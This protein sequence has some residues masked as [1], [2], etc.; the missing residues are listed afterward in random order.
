MA[1]P[2][3][4]VQQRL[5]R[6][7]CYLI[8][9]A[10]EDPDD[11]VRAASTV[12]AS[13]YQPGGEAELIRSGQTRA[14]HGRPGGRVAHNLWED[15]LRGATATTESAG[16]EAAA[17][18]SPSTQIESAPPV[19][20][21]PVVTCAPPDRARPGLHRW[22][23]DPAA[24]LP[25]WIEIRWANP[26]VIGEIQLIFDTGQHRHLTLSQADGYTKKMQWGRPQA[27]TVSDYAIDGEANGAWTEM[28]R[29][30]GNCQ[31]RRVHTFAEDR[32]VTALRVR[33]DSTHGLDHA[34]IL[35]IRAY[36]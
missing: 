5:L 22:I 36:R 28:V 21:A 31:R 12:T 13:S 20:S 19:A 32:S 26:V 11:L 3:L 7:D 27:E 34:R 24:G 16:T 15:V 23:S 10:N 9:V 18:A 6:D 30:R 29:E 4:R 2:S 8:G 1:S 14:I 33:V 25:A 17:A 35:E